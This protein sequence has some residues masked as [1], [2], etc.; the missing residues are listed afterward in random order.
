[1]LSAFV[2]VGVV[3][4]V[5]QKDMTKVFR[6]VFAVPLPELDLCDARNFP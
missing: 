5:K 1:M 3:T 2:Y 6:D 4:Y